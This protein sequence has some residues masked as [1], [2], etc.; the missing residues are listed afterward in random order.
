MSLLSQNVSKI[1]VYIRVIPINE[2]FACCF[3]DMKSFG[4]L[5]E[6]LVK[7]K[8]IKKRNYYFEMDDHIMDDELILKNNGIINGSYINVIRNDCIK[9]ELEVNDRFDK[10]EIL[11]C[12]ILVSDF[13]VIKTNENKKVKVC[14][15][16]FNLCILFYINF[17]F[18]IYKE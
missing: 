2:M 5:K 13:K 1:K 17:N 16:N 10:V 9:I 3:D 11:K 4:E 18:Y 7:R 15:N 14:V 6:D 8:F 12:Y